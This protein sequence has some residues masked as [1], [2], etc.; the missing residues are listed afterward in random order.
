MGS[1]CL[2]G[3]NVELLKV[4]DPFETH[5]NEFAFIISASIRITKSLT[6][7]LLSARN[8]CWN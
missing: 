3:L 2:T 5:L 6:G 1:G 8:S 7:A 4:A